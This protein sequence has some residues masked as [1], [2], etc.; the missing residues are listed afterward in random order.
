MSE[1]TIS[2]YFTLSYGK[3]TV[4][5]NLAHIINEHMK[6]ISHVSLLMTVAVHGCKEYCSVLAVKEQ[7]LDLKGVKAYM[8]LLVQLNKTFFNF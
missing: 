3:L 2:R 8:V 7:A 1:I 5:C 6:C 4:H